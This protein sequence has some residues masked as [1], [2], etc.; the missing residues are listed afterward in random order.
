MAMQPVINAWIARPRTAESGCNMTAMRLPGRGGLLRFGVLGPVMALRG[1]VQCTPSAPKQRALLAL[2]LLHPNELITTSRVVDELWGCRPPRSA[3]AALQMYVSAVRRRLSPASRA[4]ARQHP[5]LRTLPS[6]YAIRLEAGQLDL[7]EFRAPTGCGRAALA[8][9]Q[10]ALPGEQFSRALSLWRGSALADLSRNSMLDRYAAALEEERL[11]LLVERIGVDLC[12]GR[13]AEV[14]G[15]LEDLCDR[16]PMR[17]RMHEQLMLALSQAGRRSEALDVYTRAR[18][19][20]I[21]E[22]GIEP[23]PGLRAVQHALVRGHRPTNNGHTRH[24]VR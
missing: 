23:G 19:V 12:Q 20:M 13:G 17:E 6:G 4:D 22:A 10:C 18:N 5:V 24:E 7:A 21:D 3:V 1:D 11:A 15:E 9:R 8:T 16:F 2:L 14:V